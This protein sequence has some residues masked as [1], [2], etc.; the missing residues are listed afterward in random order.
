MKE[1]FDDEADSMRAVRTF[2]QE[3]EHASSID[4]LINASSHMAVGV[5]MTHGQIVLKMGEEIEVLDLHYAEVV[6]SGLI[7]AIETL[8]MINATRGN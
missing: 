4:G 2:L 6:A 8:R 1:H 3:A 5:D 7:M